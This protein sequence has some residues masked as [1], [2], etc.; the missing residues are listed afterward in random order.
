MS[1][2]LHSNLVSLHSETTNCQSRRTD[3]QLWITFKSCIFAFW[4]NVDLM[5]ETPYLVVNYIQI[6]YLC[7]LKQLSFRTAFCVAS[8]E[9]H[10]NLVSLHSETT[11]HRLNLRNNRLWITFKSC[12]FAFWN[13]SSTAF[14]TVATVVNYIQILYLCILKQRTKKP[15]MHGGSCELHSNLV[16]LHSETT[17]IAECLDFVGCELHSN[18]VSL[19]SETTCL[20]DISAIVKLWITFKSCIFAFWNNFSTNSS[21]Q[22]GVVNYI[23]ILYL[24]I[25]KQR[26]KPSPSIEPS[27]ELHSNLVSLHSETTTKK[28]IWYYD[29]LWITFKSCIF[30]FWNNSLCELTT[31]GRV[32]NYIKILYLCI[33]KQLTLADVVLA[34]SCELHSNLVSLHSETTCGTLPLIVPRLW[35]TFKSCIFAFWNNTRHKMP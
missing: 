32:V 35:I 5:R 1:C 26:L 20:E 8:C 7:I 23:Q 24:C 16:S 14:R 19:H 33:L 12:I 15:A 3:I 34:K 6:L 18:L 13:N 2:E 30:A 31:S 4:N 11:P 22:C 10:S 21:K 25:L 9:L 17:P 28:S 29:R 27:C